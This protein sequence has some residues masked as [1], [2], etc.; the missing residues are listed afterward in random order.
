MKNDLPAKT[1]N[2]LIIE[3]IRDGILKG[4]YKVG[5][6][7]PSETVLSRRF[8]TTRVTVGKALRDLEHEGLIVRRRGSGS[9]VQAPEQ[10]RMFTFG[11]LV[12]GLGAGE[13]FEPICNSIATT[14][15]QRNHRLLWGQFPSLN[16]SERCLHAERLCRSYIEQKVDGVFFAPIELAD[17]MYEANSRIA[18]LLEREGIPVVLLDQDVVKFPERS[19]FDLVGIDNRRAGYVLA[20]HFMERGCKRIAF[21]GQPHSAQT[22]DARIA[23]Y[24]EALA[25]QRLPAK[26][27]WIHWGDPDDPAFVDRLLKGEPPEAVLCANDFTAAK[28]IGALLRR[29]L[30]VPQ[31]I[32]VAGVD[33]LKFAG[34][35]AVSLTTIHQPCEAMGQAAAHAM[36]DRVARPDLPGRDLLLDFRLIER[37]SSGA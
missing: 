17:A 35:L 25:A 10:H 26:P 4:T 27:G 33:D 19:R 14:M 9:F 22:V 21:V 3:F 32:R 12:P 1:K 5:Q 28:L 34:L 11:L 7:I 6:R 15:A 2:A 13:I 31:D 20:T 8:Q 16:M 29:G 36:L 30:R 18:G 37:D 23:G 24:R